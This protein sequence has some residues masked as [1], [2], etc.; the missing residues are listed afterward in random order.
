MQRRV[1]LWSIAA[2]SL[3]VVVVGTSAA[4]DLFRAGPPSTPG[5]DELAIGRFQCSQQQGATQGFSFLSINGTSG[6]ASPNLQGQFTTEAGTPTPVTCESL[7]QQVAA[8]AAGK[9]CTVGPVAS[10]PSDFDSP[11]TTV[12]F[13][14]SGGHDA[15][16]AAIAAVARSLAGSTL[17]GAID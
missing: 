4:S 15:V 9:G 17:A 14:C 2:V 5:K 16:V 3:V 12:H 1:T 10:V 7:A 8:D 13:A 11:E 6:I